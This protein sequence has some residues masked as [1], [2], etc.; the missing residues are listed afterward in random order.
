MSNG[1]FDALEHYLST[2]SFVSSWTFPHP[3][4]HR[5]YVLV[6]EG[7]VG[8]LAKP[9]DAPG[10]PAAPAMVRREVAA[11]MRATS[12]GRTWYRDQFSDSSHPQLAAATS[13]PASMSCGQIASPMWTR[14]FPRTMSGVRLS[15]TRRSDPLEAG[16]PSCLQSFVRLARFILRRC[17]NS[18]Q[19]FA[20]C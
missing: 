8:V 4:Q 11:W 7:G 2:A 20:G 3:R 5:S 12:A 14:L 10:L 1:E 17:G 6:L 18:V 9:E 19:A 15:S 13:T 16:A